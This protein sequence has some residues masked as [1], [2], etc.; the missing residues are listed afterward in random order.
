MNI[1]GQ[2]DALYN[3]FALKSFR[4]FLGLCFLNGFQVVS[5][6]YF[7]ATGRPIKAATLSLSRQVLFLIPMI[8]LLPRFFGVEGILFAG[9][10]ADGLA[11]VLAAIF[12][13]LEMRHL[14]TAHMQVNETE[15]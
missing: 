14:N 1:F 8:L 4:S 15:E 10:V 9:P 6:I 13:L 7:Q 12:I 11:F 5:S 3:Q 2:E